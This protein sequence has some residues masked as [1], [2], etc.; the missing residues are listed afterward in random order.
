M[1]FKLPEPKKKRITIMG[2]PKS[3][4][5]IV[6]DCKL[7]ERDLNNIPSIQ[8]KLY[9]YEIEDIVVLFVV[10]SLMKE[11]RV[12]IIPSDEEFKESLYRAFPHLYGFLNF[13]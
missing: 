11:D 1:I 9:D 5:K 10:S 2:H 3:V 13:D 8:Y 4:D 7:L 6:G 12:Y